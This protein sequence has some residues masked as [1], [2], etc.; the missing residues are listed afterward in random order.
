MLSPGR[1]LRFLC[2]YILNFGRPFILAVSCP[3]HG[4]HSFRSLPATKLW[5]YFAWQAFWNLQLRIDH[6][7]SCSATSLLV[8]TCAL[9]YSGAKLVVLPTFP[10]CCR[11]LP[12]LRAAVLVFIQSGNYCRTYIFLEVP[13]YASVLSPRYPVSSMWQIWINWRKSLLGACLLCLIWNFAAA[14]VS[15]QFNSC[16]CPGGCFSDAGY[17]LF[18]GSSVLLSRRCCFDKNSATTAL[19]VFKTDMKDCRI[20]NKNLVYLCW[21]LSSCLDLSPDSLRF[22]RSF[23]VRSFCSRVTLLQLF[24]FCLIFCASLFSNFSPV[25]QFS[26]SGLS[27]SLLYPSALVTTSAG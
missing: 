4:V 24:S 18:E 7:D 6:W 13:D 19:Q 16:I 8:Q 22:S 27:L 9:I 11:F 26:T 21:N 10:S 15:V 2:Y 3:F 14:V 5:C 25:I 20:L 12:S 23:L 17:S 1:L